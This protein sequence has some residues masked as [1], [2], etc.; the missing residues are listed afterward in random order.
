[1]FSLTLLQPPPPSPMHSRRGT[2]LCHIVFSTHAV[3]LTCCVLVCVA[4]WPQVCSH[5]EAA[6]SG[7]YF[8]MSSSGVTSYYPDG[9][10]P[11]FMTL[12]QWQRE[13]QLHM[14]LMQLAVFRQHK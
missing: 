12:T 11:D 4:Y 2:G 3:P 7:R 13:Y 5:A 9:S 1:M 14:R 10:R 6:A 8:T